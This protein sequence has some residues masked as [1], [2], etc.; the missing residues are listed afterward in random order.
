MSQ[1]IELSA[2][3]RSDVGKGASRRLRRHANMVPGIVYGGGEAPVNVAL[4]ENSLAR[5]IQNDTF[6]SQILSLKVGDSRS[7]VIARDLQRHPASNKP[8]HIDFQR[9]VAD[10]EITVEIPIHFINEADCVGVK[11]Q[12]GMITHHVIEVEVTCLPANLPNFIEVDVKPLQLGQ[13][14]HLSDLKLPEGVELEALVGLSDEEREEQDVPVVSVQ[15]STL[16]AEMEAEE[17]AGAEGAEAPEAAAEATQPTE[18]GEA[19]K[20]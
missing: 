16:A 11:E 18:T 1:Q 20:G 9:V 4:V 17:A 2:E 12:K 14:I 6:F 13:S 3:Q 10:Q 15:A 7:Q 5:A 19:N 8:I